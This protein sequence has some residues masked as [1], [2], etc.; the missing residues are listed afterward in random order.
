M[1][2][3][4]N[5]PAHYESGQFECID[6]MLET[7]GVEKEKIYME[8]KMIKLEDIVEELL[9]LNDENLSKRVIENNDVQWCLSEL[10][11]ILTADVIIPQCKVGDMVYRIAKDGRTITEERVGAICVE[12]IIDNGTGIGD[13]WWLKDY[14]IGVTTFLTREEAEA[15]LKARD[16][17]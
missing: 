14:N 9:T 2:D 4:V 5:H 17:E 7:Q 6:V 13:V 8:K 11:D 12:Y 1:T 3:N 16:E 10:Y 15:A